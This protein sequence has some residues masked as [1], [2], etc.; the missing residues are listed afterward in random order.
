MFWAL[1]IAIIYTC[2]MAEIGDEGPE[3]VYCLHVWKAY[4]LH[5]PKRLLKC[6]LWV[7]L[8]LKCLKTRR[9]RS[10]THFVL[11]G[12][13]DGGG[14]ALLVLKCYAIVSR[15]TDHNIILKASLRVIQGMY[16]ITIPQNRGKTLC[17]LV[18][19]N[20][21]FVYTHMKSQDGTCCFVLFW[22]RYECFS[23]HMFDPSTHRA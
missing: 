7:I 10:P 13:A 23:E 8:P 5:F 9:W 17:R 16:C 20:V 6:V 22:P 19:Q 4:V 15:E 3:D 2:V 12:C 18:L 11:F 21:K 14:I 1:L